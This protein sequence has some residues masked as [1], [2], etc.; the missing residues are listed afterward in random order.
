MASQRFCCLDDR[1]AFEGW[2]SKRRGALFAPKATVRRPG[3]QLAGLY[4]DVGGLTLYVEQNLE[5]QE[6]SR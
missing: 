3:L 2:S 5:V 4:G 1:G 6:P